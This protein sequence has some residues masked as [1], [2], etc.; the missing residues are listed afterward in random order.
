MQLGKLGR[1]MKEI[2]GHMRLRAAADRHEIRQQYFSLLW[3]RLIRRLMD[4]GK[5]IVDEVIDLM[6]SYFLTREDWDAM[7]ELG[8]GPMDESKVKLESQT[9]AAFTR[10]Y[11]QRSHPL[12]FM[13]ASSVVA[14]K[15]QP[16]ERPDIEDAIDE[17]DEEEEVVDAEVKEDDDDELDLKKDKYVKVPKKAAARGGGG[18][19]G[20]KATKGKKVKDED[21]D[22]FIDDE[23]EKPKKGRSKK[24]KSKA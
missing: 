21:E 20:K 1:L 2:Q 5:D 4:E 18:A 17:S 11:N 13:K 3:D 12:P 24:G 19:K 10:V 8:L 6:D 9:K 23:D 22:D 16:K 15:R 7:V 14:P